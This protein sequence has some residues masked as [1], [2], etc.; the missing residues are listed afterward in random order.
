[1]RPTVV[2]PSP[3]GVN[4]DL[5]LGRSAATRSALR[6]SHLRMVLSGRAASPLGGGDSQ[7][8][9]ESKGQHGCRFANLVRSDC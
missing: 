5:T 4:D 9:E 8:G 3:V 2:N 7:N 1:M 6:P